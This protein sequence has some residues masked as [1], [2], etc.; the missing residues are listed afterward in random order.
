MR[1]IIS[2]ERKCIVCETTQ[3]LHKHHIFFGAGR[4][5]T[6][7]QYGCWCYLCAR[8]HNMS[9][10]GVHFNSVFDRKLK[11]FAQKRFIEVYPELDFLK[12]FGK[13]YL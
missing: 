13:N 2:N 4:R 6:S 3:D 1:S 12:I 8:H 7:E 9:E 11:E 10:F 5:E